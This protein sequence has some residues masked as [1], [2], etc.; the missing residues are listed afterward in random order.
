MPELRFD[1]TTLGEAMLR[2]SVPTGQRLET[3]A[4][5]DLAA[6]GA[7]ANVVSALA[8]IGRRAGWVSAL[9][10]SALGRFV[11]NHLRAA[12]VDLAGVIW[13]QT[14][15]LGT[16][17]VEF[18]EPPRATQVI[19]DRAD[20][21][22]AQLAPDQ[23]AWDYLLDTRLLHLT[24]IT[25]ALSASCAEVVAEALRRARAA[26]VA[27]SFDINYRAK[28]WSEDAAR[29]GLLPL[30]QD[31]DLLLCGQSDA[32]RVF[33]CEGT[34][35]QIVR[36]LRDLSGARQVV[37]TVGGGDVVTWDGSAQLSQAPIPVTIVDR[38]G[39]GDAF[40]AGVLH[41][42]L[43]GDLALGLRYGVTLAAL[44]LTQHGDAVIT[45]LDEVTS[46][47]DNARG[48]LHR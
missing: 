26:G 8:R 46:L 12:G 39:A 22:A 17:Y 3:A 19:Y 23:I 34:P 25:P 7:E 14:G 37:L 36:A 20:S 35:D 31:V 30:I 40:A 5:L 6:A 16:Y 21:C 15:R 10:D 43:D 4:Q 45:T 28:L 44:A 24:G 27:V 41:G 29:D 1:V 13:S 48:G 2:Q 18:S 47:L 38:L 11:G 42:W 33:G 9:P 32:Q